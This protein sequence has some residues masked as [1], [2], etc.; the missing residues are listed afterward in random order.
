MKKAGT[1]ISL[2]RCCYR[3]M[4]AMD[5]LPTIRTFKFLFG[6]PHLYRDYPVEVLKLLT[7]MTKYQIVPDEGI[8]DSIN[9][10]GGEYKR[11]RQML[12]ALDI[13]KNIKIPWKRVHLMRLASQFRDSEIPRKEVFLWEGY[14]LLQKGGEQDPIADV[15]RSFGEYW[16]NDYKKRFEDFGK[17][18][19]ITR[20]ALQ[21][22][23]LD[24]KKLRAAIL[25]PATAGAPTKAT[26][27]PA[28]PG[29]APPP[30]AAAPPPK[31]AATPKG[32]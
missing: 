25:P 31:T 30:K 3:E 7:D 8:M 5:I 1:D 19:V 2:L 18:Q 10:H 15:E 11:T 17:V 20:K 14:R 26:A 22:R 27:G 23:I 6:A 32:K 21:P 12:E 4:K 29:A 28:K 16:I 9:E 13:M 24:I